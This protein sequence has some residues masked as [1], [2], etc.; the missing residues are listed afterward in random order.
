MSE[1]KL[2]GRKIKFFRCHID[3]SIG[4]KPKNAFDPVDMRMQVCEMTPVGIYTKLLDGSESVVP[5]PNIQSIRLM[6]EEAVVAEAIQ[7]KT[8]KQA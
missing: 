1:I 2:S 3:P 6:P 7:S 5:Y 4:P 8:K